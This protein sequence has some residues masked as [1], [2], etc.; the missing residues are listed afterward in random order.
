MASIRAKVTAGGVKAADAIP[1][2]YPLLRMISTAPR[3]ILQVDL[4]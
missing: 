4:S 1:E 3:W 2:K